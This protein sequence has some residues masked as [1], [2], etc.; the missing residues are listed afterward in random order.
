[1]KMQGGMRSSGR[2]H[3][4][5]P[6]ARR[7]P[8]SLQ[9]HVL[10][11]HDT[12]GSEADRKL[13]LDP[14]LHSE[15][16]AAM[17]AEALREGLFEDALALADRRCRIGPMA[18]ASHY[19]LRATAYSHLGEREL[20][21]LDI[22]KAI[23]IEPENVLTNRA[24]L[25]STSKDERARAAKTLIRQDRRPKVLADAISALDDLAFYSIG[26]LRPSFLGIQGWL[27]WRGKDALRLELAWNGETVTV[28]VLPEPVHEFAELLGSAADVTLEWPDGAQF[29]EVR[30]P[31]GPFLFLDL[32][33]L[34][35]IVETCRATRRDFDHPVLKNHANRNL[36]VI[37]PIYKDYDATL[38]CL[39]AL[40]DECRACSD[41]FIVVVD[42]ASP[43]PLIRKLLD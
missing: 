20:A 34:R 25:A 15:R 14:L 41:Q 30:A 17:A 8:R 24:L 22:R 42:D 12:L 13:F 35:P 9:P 5:L 1:M 4:E 26:V 31:T 29:V 27:V 28:E 7:T 37:V 36:A 18:E 23:E 19:L 40:V 10:E 6:S 33:L 21:L 38:T 11:A 2:A 32:T 3:A 39:T 16:L 43:D